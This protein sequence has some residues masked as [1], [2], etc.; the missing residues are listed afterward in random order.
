ME[1]TEH[2]KQLMSSGK[3]ND[4]INLLKAAITDNPTDD[5]ALYMLGNAYCRLS[6]W[7]NASACYHQVIDLNPDS[8]SFEAYKKIQFFFFFYFYVLYNP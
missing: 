4:A 7:R 5:R 1:N 2:V 3:V 8:P 6:D